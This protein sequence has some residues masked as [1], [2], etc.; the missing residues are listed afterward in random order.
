MAEENTPDFAHRLSQR[1]HLNDIH[2]KPQLILGESSE[3]DDIFLSKSK[4]HLSVKEYK[5][6]HGEDIESRSTDSES[7]S[8]VGDLFNTEVS[9]YQV[10]VTSFIVIS[11]TCLAVLFCH[12]YIKKLL[13][14]LEDVDL[15]VGFLIFILLFTLVSFPVAWGYM[16]LM[17]AC[18]YLYGYIYGPLVVTFF[19]AVGILIAHLTMK[20]CCRDWILTKFYNRQIEAFITVVESKQGFK[21]VALSRLTPI[22]FGLQNGIFSLTNIPLLKYS[23]ASAIGLGPTAVLNCYMGS[24]LRSME[25]VLSDGSSA[26][27]GYIIFAIQIIITVILL[28]FVVRKARAELK[29]AVEGDNSKAQIVPLTIDDETVVLVAPEILKSQGS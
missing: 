23:A 3:F 2:V 4:Q 13:I 19:G 6:N 1:L 12:Q 15:T 11:L 17:L 9:C 21:I 27:T 24:T 25:D 18:G 10:S 20:H 8:E 29:K 28:T 22:P 16:L 14:W 7:S 26:T 5:L